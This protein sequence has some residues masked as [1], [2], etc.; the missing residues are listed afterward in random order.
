[1]YWVSLSLLI[2]G[3]LIAVYLM[4]LSLSMSQAIQHQMIR[5]LVNTELYSMLKEVTI[6]Y[7]E[8]LSNTYLMGLRKA[9]EN[10][11]QDT[12]SLAEI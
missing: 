6:A 12:Q 11:S 4:T 3:T 5:S 2:I 8:M 9:M 7:F 10:L 1:M